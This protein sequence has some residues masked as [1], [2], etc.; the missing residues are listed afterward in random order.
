MK[1]LTD[2]EL[3]N[4]IGGS[5]SI[6]ATLIKAFVEAFSSIID[7]G[8]NVGSSLRRFIDNRECY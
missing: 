6:S 8:R 2:Q 7:A 4:I 5:I 3:T 1:K